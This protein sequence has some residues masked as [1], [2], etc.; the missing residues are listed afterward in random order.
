[1]YR[2]ATGTRP[3]ERENLL[4]V[5]QAVL[6]EALPAPKEVL[7]EIPEDLSDLIAHALQKDPAARFASAQQMLGAL[8]GLELRTDSGRIPREERVPLSERLKRFTNRLRRR[9]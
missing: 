7:P 8:R 9:R 2:M 5:F 3:F 4:G 6:H 1:M